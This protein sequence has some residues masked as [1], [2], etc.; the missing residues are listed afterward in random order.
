[1]NLE[2]E[3]YFDDHFGS[4]P[5]CH[6]TNGY[7]NIGRH[8][9]FCCSKHRTRW[10]VGSNLL[11]GW[12]V[13]D[14][15]HGNNIRENIIWQKNALLLLQCTEVE[16]YYSFSQKDLIQ[17]RDVDDYLPS[18]L[19][20]F[21]TESELNEIYILENELIKTY[22]YWQENLDSKLHEELKSQISKT[23]KSWI[24]D[25]KT[26]LVINRSGSR[27][28]LL[29]ALE[30]VTNRLI[31]VSPWI[32]K[33]GCDK[34]LLRKIR[35]VLQK[36]NARVHIGWGY[37]N[38]LGKRRSVHISRKDFLVSVSQA[39]QEW[40]YG[41]LPDLELLEQEYSERFKLKLLGTHE[42]FFICDNQ[43]A[44]IGSHN[45]LASSEKSAERE[46]GYR[47]TE[48]EIISDLIE[49]FDKSENLES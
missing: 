43:F 13:Y 12:L 5:I 24:K 2:S 9:W 48:P 4:C 19:C 21:F 18:I 8:Y 39:S 25:Y 47:I 27:A 29:E 7:A 34:L 23:I 10:Y 31:I 37:L 14:L 20:E 11:S 6:L 36:T 1:M 44:V 15:K 49:H 33:Y 32:T 42:K 40:K 38:D 26:Q 17:I 28:V 22:E 30:R 46:L 35:E 16:P 45:V 41:A 3:R